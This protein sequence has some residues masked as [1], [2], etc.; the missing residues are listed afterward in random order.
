MGS[1]KILL[2]T[3][4]ISLSGAPK[5]LLLLWRHIRNIENFSIDVV[6]F[7]EEGKLRK[8]F[9]D[10][11]DNFYALPSFSKNINWSF[12]KRVLRKILKIEYTSEYDEFIDLLKSNKYDCIFANTVLTI[13]FAQSIKSNNTTLVVNVHELSTVIDEFLPNINDYSNS[14]DLFIVPSMLNKQVLTNKSI[15][16]SK[17]SI[18]R[19][20]SML[21]FRGLEFNFDDNANFRVI[22]CGAAYWRKGDDLFLQLASITSKID[23]TIKFYWVGPQS[24]EKRRVNNA[25]ILK[26]G[27]AD[28]LFFIDEVEFND[29]LSSMD[30]FAL[31]S[32]ED[33]FPLAAVEAGLYGLP[34]TCF[35]KSTGISEV[36]SANLIADY[37]D[38]YKMS[39][40]IISLSQNKELYNNEA[41][42]NKEH[43]KNFLPT[44]IAKQ[45][46]DLLKKHL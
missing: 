9:E 19:D 41:Q 5:M 4:D 24:S 10:F 42:K 43:F 17:I 15:D 29:L 28:N 1:K 27:L 39:D 46:V 11:A 21:E 2:I 32:R 37:M 16:G 12:K 26:L 35:S 8:R 13:P 6:S 23:P 45:I 30:V 14:I 44:N 36:I 40:I 25:D 31:T 20:S 34:I 33:P 22:G 3:H 7:T 38:V 18:I